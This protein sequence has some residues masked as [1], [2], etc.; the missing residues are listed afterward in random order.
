MFPGMGEV[1]TSLPPGAANGT[2]K[3]PL[4]HAFIGLANNLLAM[5]YLIH[6]GVV[7]LLAVLAIR[8]NAFN[9]FEATAL[10]GL[11]RVV[12]PP[13]RGENKDDAS[14][15]YVLRLHKRTL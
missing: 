13:E 9:F 5:P 3:L 15:A 1:D 8:F 4:L 6:A 12:K 11:V 10:F 14:Q 2:L 7:R